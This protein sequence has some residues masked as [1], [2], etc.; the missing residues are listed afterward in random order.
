MSALPFGS[1]AVVPHSENIEEAVRWLMSR[2]REEI[3]RPLVPALR[4]RFGLSA[5][6]ACAVL[7]EFGL[8]MG[9]AT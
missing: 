4:E 3:P 7:R 8:I 5:K 6:D 1:P 9:R 2:S